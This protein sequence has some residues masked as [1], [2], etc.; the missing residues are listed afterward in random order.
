MDKWNS[1]RDIYPPLKEW[2]RVRIRDCDEVFSKNRG[3]ILLVRKTLDGVLF[4]K[5]VSCGFSQEVS[6]S[7]KPWYQRVTP[8]EIKEEDFL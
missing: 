6:R 8:V 7:S 4:A 2:D 3:Q 1:L 5:G